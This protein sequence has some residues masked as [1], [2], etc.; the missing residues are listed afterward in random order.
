[1]EEMGRSV[2]E[3]EVRKDPDPQICG[4]QNGFP[5]MTRAGACQRKGV[6]YRVTCQTCLKEGTIV[7]YIGESSHTLFDRGLEHLTAIRKRNVESP[8]VEHA[9]KKNP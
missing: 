1:M 7:Y 6:V 5:C 9:E 8:M 4:H 3:L 2:R